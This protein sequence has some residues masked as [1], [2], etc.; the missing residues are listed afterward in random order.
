MRLKLAGNKGD[1]LIAIVH[2][3]EASATIPV[4]TPVVLKLNGTN[5]G[6]DVCLPATAGAVLSGSAYYGCV[7]TALTAGSYGESVIFGMVTNAVVTF[8]TR[9]ASSN[10]W[11]SSASWAQGVILALDT[12]NNAFLSASASNT[13]GPNAIYAV[14]ASSLPSSTAS[15]T[16]TS[17]TRTVITN[18]ARVFVRMI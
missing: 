2:N 1:S 12:V 10:S 13:S 8:M 14:L 11:S 5:D 7:T 15:A 9:A 18:S 17:D 16:T 3:A 4:G 6:L